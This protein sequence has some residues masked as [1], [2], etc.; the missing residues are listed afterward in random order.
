MNTN[1]ILEKQTSRKIMRLCICLAKPQNIY[2]EG[3]GVV[4]I[5]TVK[6]LAGHKDIRMTQRDAHHCPE[7]L[8]DG[9][10]VLEFGHDLVTV[11]EN[12]NV[13]SA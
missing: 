12:R 8:R 13:S 2:N 7:T 3:Q 4:D 11:G 1:K 9:V 5:V 6:E 10:Q